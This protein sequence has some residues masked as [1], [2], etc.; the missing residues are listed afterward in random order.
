MRLMDSSARLLGV[1][2]ILQL[3]IF[4]GVNVN[5]N[6]LKLKKLY[7]DI[8]VFTRT[9]WF[10]LVCKQNVGFFLNERNEDQ[11]RGTTWRLYEYV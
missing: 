1:F 5:I 9:I 2:E 11:S 10:L 7:R 4:Y 6:F 8:P 3:I